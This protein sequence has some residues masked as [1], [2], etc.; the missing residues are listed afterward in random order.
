MP[1]M[2]DSKSNYSAHPT[3]GLS[4]SRRWILQK[5]RQKH[6]LRHFENVLHNDERKVKPKM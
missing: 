4:D 2:L 3:S 5:T 6:W 1:S